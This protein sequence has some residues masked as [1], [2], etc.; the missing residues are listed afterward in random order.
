MRGISAVALA[1]LGLA[2]RAAPASAQAA[3]AEERT[4]RYL[5][6]VRGNTP[7]VTAFLREMPKGAD[8]HN[9]LSGAVYAESYVQWAADSSFCVVTST[10]TLASAPCDAEAGKVPAASALTNGTLY[11][12]L[13]DA[14]SMRNW[15]PARRNGHDQFFDTFGKFGMATWGRT[16][17][18]LAEATSRAALGHVSYMEL[19]QTPDEGSVAALGRSVGWDPDFA[20]MRQKLLAA[21]L[22]D[23]LAVASRK[24][25]AAEAHQRQVLHCAGTGAVGTGAGPSTGG[26]PGCGVTVRWLYQ[27]S[28]ARPPEQVFAQILAGFEMASTDPRVVGLNLVQAEDALLSMRDFTL[29][30]RMIDFLHRLYPAVHVTLHA[31]ELTPGLVPPEGL[32]FHVRQSVEL[33]HAERIGHGVDVMNEERPYDLLRE[34]AAKNVMVEIAL[35]SNDVILGVSGPNHP[36]AAYRRY[37]VPVALATDD[38]GVSRS[39]LSMEY[40]RGVRDQGLGYRE[41]KTMARTSLEHAFV[42][43]ASAW[44]DGRAFV[45]VAECAPAA[46]GWE[47]ASCTRFASTS[48][49]ATLQRQLEIDLRDFER[50]YAAMAVSPQVSKR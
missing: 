28:R 46:G 50:R 18:M 26:D 6:S 41:L 10:L 19:M 12:Q 30:M 2:F 43:G 8:L 32:R 4:A 44:R 49:K 37:G 38:E 13:V 22:R 17:D 42:Q 15:N 7:L 14:W 40:L 36:L 3:S 1:L 16:G 25:A 47:G 35:T 29:H 21:G 20:R 24:L 48:A 33:G 39:D 11:G 31:G 5:D 23:T 34:M 27:V 45:P 9:H